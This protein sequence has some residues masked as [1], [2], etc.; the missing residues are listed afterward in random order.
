MRVCVL[1]RLKG[2]SKRLCF[3]FIFPSYS[4]PFSPSIPRSHCSESPGSPPHTH[5]LLS[6][7]IWP[8]PHSLLISI[9]F[10]YCHIYFLVPSFFFF[11]FHPIYPVPAILQPQFPPLDSYFTSLYSTTQQPLP[12]I[13]LFFF[14]QQIL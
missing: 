6:S 8:L 2:N 14:L 11:T 13:S 12:I 10:P 3:Y 7:S 4:F 9:S 5:F 1:S